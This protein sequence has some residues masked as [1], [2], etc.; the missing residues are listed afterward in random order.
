MR[1]IV[2]LNSVSARRGL[3]VIHDG[4]VREIT[5]IL[6]RRLVYNSRHNGSTR[7]GPLKLPIRGNL[8]QV[9]DITFMAVAR[10]GPPHV[11]PHTGFVAMC[12]GIIR[13]LTPD[14]Q[15]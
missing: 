6:R 15:Q 13:V 8:H 1:V 3:T 4:C 12:W 10:R 14:R 5:S 11:L 9:I 2:R 7:R